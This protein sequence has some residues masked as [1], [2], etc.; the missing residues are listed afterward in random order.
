MSRRTSGYVRTREALLISRAE[1]ER[2]IG[3]PLDTSR[4]LVEPGAPTDIPD[5]AGAIDQALRSRPELAA[6]D[7][8]LLENSW[9]LEAARA[10]RKPELNLSGTAQYLGPNRFEGW[11]D[12][13]DPGLKTYRLFAGLGLS[14]PLYDVGLIRA[15]VGEV[16]ADRS[17][18]TARRRISRWDSP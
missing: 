14:M 15:R 2:E 8:G 6:A 9:R 7:Q 16:A 12:V 3:A 17:A 1:L 11:W 5:A 18:L 13:S 4:T 10:A